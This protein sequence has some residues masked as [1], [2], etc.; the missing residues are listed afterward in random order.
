VL[1]QNALVPDLVNQTR[2]PKMQPHRMGDPPDENSFH[3]VWTRELSS[4]REVH[5]KKI[6]ASTQAL[7]DA[8]RRV[9]EETNGIF[10][11]FNA[12]DSLNQ[13]REEYAKLLEYRRENELRLLDVAEV[14]G[15][16]IRDKEYEHAVLEHRK[17]HREHF[18]ALSGYLRMVGGLTMLQGARPVAI[19][20]LADSLL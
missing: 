3:D 7:A 10:N 16:Q 18:N 17:K 5:E 2:V 11:K 13:M 20:T 8:K 14:G 15:K 4:I 12:L 9:E 19:R 1:V 6:I